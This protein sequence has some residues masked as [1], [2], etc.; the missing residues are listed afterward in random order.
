M[1]DWI[2][3]KDRLPTP[4][5]DCRYSLYLAIHAGWDHHA[6]V[7]MFDNEMLN[8][9]RHGDDTQKV[10]HWMPLPEPPK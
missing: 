6:T 9:T 5:S 4:S 1:S 3:V 2:S 10:T 7:L 8:F